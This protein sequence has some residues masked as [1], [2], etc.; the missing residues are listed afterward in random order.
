MESKSKP[1]SVELKRP[2]YGTAPQIKI[3]LNSPSEVAGL[4]SRVAQNNLRITPKPQARP[5]N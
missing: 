1:D 5:G 3:N 4:L 2:I